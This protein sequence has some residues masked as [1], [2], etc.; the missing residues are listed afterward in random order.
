[1]LAKLAADIRKGEI[2]EVQALPEEGPEAEAQRMVDEEQESF[3]DAAA[4]NMI[5]YQVSE[6]AKMDNENGHP[7]MVSNK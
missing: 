6:D 7:L 3:Y 2:Q 1:M 4:E 5:I